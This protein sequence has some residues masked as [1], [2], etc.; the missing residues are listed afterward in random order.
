MYEAGIEAFLAIIE[1]RSLKKAG[2]MLS[3]TQA[4]ISYRLKIL[5]QEMGAQLIERN[6]GIQQITLTAFGEN[7]VPI[8]NRWYLLKEDMKKLQNNGYQHCLSIG[9][10][11]SLNTYVLPPLYQALSRHSPEINLTFRTQHSLELWEAMERHEINV[12]FVKME[13]SAP[14]I[15]IKPFFVDEVV[16]LRPAANID[17]ALQP[18]HPTE[19][20][21][22]HEIYWNWG[23]SFQCWHNHWWGSLHP[24]YTSV[25]IASLIFTLMQDPLQWSVVPLSVAKSF[26]GS[27]KFVIQKLLDPPPQRTSYMITPVNVKPSFKDSLNILNK[28]MTAIFPEYIHS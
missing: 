21:P 18:I 19:V 17:S 8:A 5:E 6:K 27:K 9:G 15:T 7:F 24:A 28:Y 16:L 1:A 14:N 13:K 3:L 23:P 20:N 11:N 26:V 2:E 12:G 10:S 25:D 4:T 22:K